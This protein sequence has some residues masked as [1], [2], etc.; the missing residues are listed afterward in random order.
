MTALEQLLQR[1]GHGSYSFGATPTLADC[2]LVPQVANALRMGCDLSR[3]ER[4]MSIHN[5][6]QGLAAFKQA[7]PERQPDFTV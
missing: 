6:C 2:C 7:A 5:Q 1:H 4:V 3:F